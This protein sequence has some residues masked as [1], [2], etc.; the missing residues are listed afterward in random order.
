MRAATWPEI[1][2]S[3]PILVRGRPYRRFRAANMCMFS[4]RPCHAAWS[5]RQSCSPVPPTRCFRSAGW[6][7]RARRPYQPF[8]RGAV[9][10]E[11]V[12]DHGAGGQPHGAARLARS[13]ARPGVCAGVAGRPGHREGAF[14]VGARESWTVVASRS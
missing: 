9:G 4:A 14:V 11:A 10:W 2:D 13:C 3:D 12:L 5:A 6:E 7:C 1:M 8:R